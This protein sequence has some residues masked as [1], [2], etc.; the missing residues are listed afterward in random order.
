MLFRFVLHYYLLRG[1]YLTTF[2][3]IRHPEWVDV[4][5]GKGWINGNGENS[6]KN[7]ENKIK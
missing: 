2:S 6:V 3:K 7:E 1:T 4:E 5:E